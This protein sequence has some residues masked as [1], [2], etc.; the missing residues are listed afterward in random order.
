MTPSVV[1]LEKMEGIKVGVADS[2]L[3]PW[4]I[5]SHDT[6]IFPLGYTIEKKILNLHVFAA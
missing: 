6:I 3:F 4:E 1:L 2:A 5:F